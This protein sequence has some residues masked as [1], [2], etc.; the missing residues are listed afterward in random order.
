MAPNADLYL[1]CVDNNIGFCQVAA[2]DRRGR[3]IKVVNSSL[4]FAGRDPR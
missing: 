3:N 2:G 1:Y 4:S